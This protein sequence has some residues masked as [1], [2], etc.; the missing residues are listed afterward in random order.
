[1]SEKS[2]RDGKIG[3]DFENLEFTFILLLRFKSL[4]CLRPVLS[5]GDPTDTYLNGRIKDTHR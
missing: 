5:N 3:V 4:L 1:M 2:F